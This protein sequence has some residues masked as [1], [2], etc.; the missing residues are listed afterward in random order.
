MKT[1]HLDGELFQDMDQKDRNTDQDFQ[2]IQ[3]ALLALLAACAQVMELTYNRS[4]TDK[5][6]NRLGQGLL[7]SIQLIT[8]AHN[9]L[10]VR[11]RELLR[12]HLS[13]IYANMM[14]KSHS[15]SEWL[16]GGDLGETTK[17]CDLAQKVREKVC[18]RVNKLLPRT[19]QQQQK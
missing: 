7:H 16:Y 15:M 17:V 5:E 19:G 4:K 6:L 2:S 13:L 9:N 3:K 8:L 18:K 12:P 11:R 14:T 1:P 10:S